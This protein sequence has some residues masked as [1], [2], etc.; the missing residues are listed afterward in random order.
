MPDLVA[1]YR[2]G[3]A[4]AG[5]EFRPLIVPWPTCISAGVNQLQ[6]PLLGPSTSLTRTS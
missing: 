3:A 4:H 2:G 1:T 5:G 6:R